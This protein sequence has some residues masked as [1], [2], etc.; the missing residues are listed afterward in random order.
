[1][2]LIAIVRMTQ[3]E[4]YYFNS[5]RRS[6]RGLNSCWPGQSG[7]LNPPLSLEYKLR[8]PFPKTAASTTQPETA[9]RYPDH[10]AKSITEPIKASI[11][12]LKILSVECRDLLVLQ[13]L[14]MSFLG[15]FPCVLFSFYW[16]TI[17]YRFQ[18]Y[19]LVFQ[20]L[21]YEMLTW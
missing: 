1:M 4:G 5:Y 20:R 14:K 12:T 7:S 8:P 10:L 18:V 17:L 19:N 11:Q 16:H 21:F 2:L 15:K 3:L 9:V 13:E 6:C